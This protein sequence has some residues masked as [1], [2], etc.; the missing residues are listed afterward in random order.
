[1]KPLLIA[2]TL[3]LFGGGSIAVAQPVLPPDTLGVTV[4]EGLLL[5]LN[6]QLRPV[7]TLTALLRAGYEGGPEHRATLRRFVADYREARSSEA[8][9]LVALH[10]LS[11]IG[12]ESDYFLDLA[13]RWNEGGSPE[14]RDRHYWLAYYA[15]N[16]LARDPTPEVL[17]VLDSI[18]IAARRDGYLGGTYLRARNIAFNLQQYEH[19]TSV[20][21]K[22]DRAIRW[23]GRGWRISDTSRFDLDANL[24]AQ[25][26]VGQRWLEELSQQHPQQVAQAIAEIDLPEGDALNYREPDIR[27][28]LASFTS[29]EVRAILAT[30]PNEH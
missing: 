21:E 28:Y 19:L 12:E 30:L 22:I 20:P 15:M 7:E 13:R 26:V 4:D 1:M 16:M 8:Y 17:A 23:A 6:E 9:A 29:T 3:I 18:S 5:A 27:A 2:G 24:S 10:S 25:A 14:E 11:L